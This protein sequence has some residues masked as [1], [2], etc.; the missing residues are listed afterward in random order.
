MKKNRIFIIAL[1]ACILLAGCSEPHHNSISTITSGTS[2]PPESVTTTVSQTTKETTTTVA[3]TSVSMIETTAGT[4]TTKCKTDDYVEPESNEV[5][6]A[7]G[8]E[9]WHVLLPD[10]S[11][12]VNF[13]YFDATTVPPVATESLSEPNKSYVAEATVTTTYATTAKPKETTAKRTTAETETPEVIENSTEFIDDYTHKYYYNTLTDTQ[14]AYYRYCFNKKR[15]SINGPEPNYS[16]TD[17]DIAYYAFQR[18]NPHLQLYPTQ[19]QIDN[20]LTSMT[21]K[22]RNKILKAAKAI[23]D[24]VSEYDQTFDKIKVIHDELR[25]LIKYES[26]KEMESAFLEGKADCSGYADAFCVVCQ[27]AGIDC[28]VV[29]GTAHNGAMTS[30][31]AW[32]MVKIADDWYN[33][34]VCWDDVRLFTHTYFLRSDKAFSSNHTVKMPISCPKATKRY[35]VD[36]YGNEAA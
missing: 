29:W 23:A 17:K 3:A 30:D 33:V 6:L 12:V 34:D 36:K 22:K 24:K 1:C 9:P 7:A 4:T 2:A 28:I 8:T 20:K 10:G 21:P 25:D 18:E 11:V 27:L 31:H 32:N 16:S 26:Y 35:P 15:Y 13:E 14:K 5:M 19:Y